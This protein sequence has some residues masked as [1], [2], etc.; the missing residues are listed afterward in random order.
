MKNILVIRSEIFTI[1]HSYHVW[2]IY[3]INDLVNI[4]GEPLSICGSI[5]NF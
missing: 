3:K 1:C 2:V 4:R 5:Y